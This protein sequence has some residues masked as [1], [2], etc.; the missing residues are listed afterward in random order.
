MS[1][2]LKH[3]RQSEVKA[4]AEKGGGTSKVVKDGAG[5]SINEMYKKLVASGQM[6]L[7]IG[8]ATGGKM[9]EAQALACI[10]DART[11]PSMWTNEEVRVLNEKIETLQQK[12]NEEKYKKFIEEHDK[13]VIENFKMNNQNNVQQDN[14]TVN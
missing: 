11:M 3:Q 9:T 7:V 4:T 13:K 5:L 2:K 12:L 10:K 8:H 1:E 14:I 6:S